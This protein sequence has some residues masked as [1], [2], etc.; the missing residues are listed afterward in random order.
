MDVAA[1]SLAVDSSDVVKAANDLD[2]FAAS[3]TKAGAA[4]GNQNGSIARLVA[5]VQSTNAKLTAL[6]GAVEKL[7]SS[8]NGA[9]A[10]A[11]NMA[12]AND[13]VSRALGVADAHVIAYTVSITAKDSN[14][15]RSETPDRTY[16]DT[17]Q[18]RRA[19]ELGVSVDRG[20]EY[21]VTLANRTYQVP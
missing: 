9:A 18:K 1:L 19:I 21:L 17:M 7:T 10:A 16:A 15:G 14:H 20:A 13:N 2:R 3:A 11:Q 5:S 4:A 8:Q 6:I 12:S